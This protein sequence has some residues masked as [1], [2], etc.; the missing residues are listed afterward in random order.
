MLPVYVQH[1]V[2]QIEA[3]DRDGSWVGSSQQSSYQRQDVS[4]EGTMFISCPLADWLCLV[5]SDELLYAL[6]FV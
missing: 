3:V 5:L 4:C 2:G 6:L 1:L